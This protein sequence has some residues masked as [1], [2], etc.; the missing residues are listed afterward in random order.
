MTAGFD[1]GV[2]SFNHSILINRYGNL[3]GNQQFLRCP[4]NLFLFSGRWIDINHEFELS[5][6][7]HNSGTDLVKQGTGYKGQNGTKIL[8]TCYN[9]SG[10]CEE[11]SEGPYSVIMSLQ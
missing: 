10:Y 8:H 5:E 9:G 7:C 1:P 2:C 6:L 4:E 3:K 11:N